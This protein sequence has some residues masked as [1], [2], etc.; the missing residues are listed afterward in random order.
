MA[1]W[2][3]MPGGAGAGRKRTVPERPQW[4][5]ADV[6]S[7]SRSLGVLGG[8]GNPAVPVGTGT[9]WGQGSLA[10][11]LPW[12]APSAPSLLGPTGLCR[13]FVFA[14]GALRPCPGTTLRSGES[15]NSQAPG[16]A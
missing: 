5:E 2:G 10:A 11:V 1:W 13:L 4:Q 7:W 14:A 8:M 12:P 3:C 9:A 6:L 16:S 15:W